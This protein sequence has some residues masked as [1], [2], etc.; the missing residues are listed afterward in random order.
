MMLG[1]HIKNID[2]IPLTI[3]IMILFPR[4][5]GSRRSD[6]FG[7]GRTSKVQCIMV[8]RCSDATA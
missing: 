7:E 8:Q 3:K 1:C 5:Y 4:I 2:L 6:L